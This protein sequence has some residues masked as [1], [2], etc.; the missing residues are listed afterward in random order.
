MIF[1]ETPNKYENPICRLF[2]TRLCGFLLPFIFLLTA[3]IIV[4]CAFLYNWRSDYPDL[5]L[6]DHSDS[7]YWYSVIFIER[8]GAKLKPKK[9][10][11]K[12]LF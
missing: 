11:K 12:V 5:I 10:L 9:I 6:P 8:K 7:W 3:L 2:P 4:I 1:D